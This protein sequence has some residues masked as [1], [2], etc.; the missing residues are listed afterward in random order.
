MN[1]NDFRNMSP[2]QDAPGVDAANAYLPYMT[3]NEGDFSSFAAFWIPGGGGTMF[4][5]ADVESSTGR[6]NSISQDITMNELSLVSVYPF[7][8]CLLHL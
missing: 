7:Q 6:D 1:E 2:P 5:E 8:L 3:D 4:P